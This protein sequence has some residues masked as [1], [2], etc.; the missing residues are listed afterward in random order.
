[1]HI[2]ISIGNLFWD[3]EDNIKNTFPGKECK[4]GLDCFG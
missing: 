2:K 1:M 3:T 4:C